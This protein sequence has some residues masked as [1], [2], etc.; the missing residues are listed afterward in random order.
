MKSFINFVNISKRYVNNVLLDNVNL[1]IEEKSKI[2]VIGRNGAGKTTLIKILLGE[3]EADD[4][5][6]IL[7]NELKIGYLKQQD[8]FNENEYILDYLTRISGKESWQCAKT[9]ANFGIDHDRVKLTISTLSSGFRM[10]LKLTEMML[11]EPNFLLLDEPSNFLDLNTLIDL[12]NFLLDYTGGYLI[13]SHDREFLKVTCDRTLEVQNGKCIYFMG[14]IEDYFEYK[15]EQEDYIKRY[16]KNINEKKAHLQKFVERFRY[17]ASKAAAAQSKMKQIEKLKHIEISHPSKNVKIKI[18]SA[19]DKKGFALIIDDLSVGYKDKVVAKSGRIEI[20]RGRHVAVLGENGQGKTTFLRTI[21]GGLSKLDGDYKFAQ[22]IKIAYFAEHIYKEIT[23]TD[24][25]FSYLRRHA[26]EGLMQ[27][28]LLS[29]LGSF[30]FSGDDVYKSVSVL[31]GGEK[32]RLT[33]LAAITQCADVLILDEPTNHLDFETVEALASSLRDYKGTILFTSHDRTF[34]SMLANTIIEVKDKTVSIYAGDYDS[35]V[36][37]LRLETAK[38]EEEEIRYIEIEES[39]NKE[40][41]EV[42]QL[43]NK[44]DLTYDERKKIKNKVSKLKSTIKE[45]EK[46][47]NELK[48]EEREISSYFENGGKYDNSKIERMLELKN[49]IEEKEIEWLEI[50]KETEEMEKDYNI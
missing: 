16:N 17:K 5:E 28:E 18:P 12:E 25:V 41:L 45:I 7:A 36:Y 11:H 49:I 44:T 43:I 33:L 29:L 22:G 4:G 42:A 46:K 10:R 34:V 37:H 15:E 8:D 9:A 19:V 38:H 14:G 13:V 50:H 27:Q 1:L 48:N 47:L 2:G 31:S 35:Y 23:A 20:E 6:V 32:S 40:K 26:K 30:L 24:K 3:E 39:K 21:A